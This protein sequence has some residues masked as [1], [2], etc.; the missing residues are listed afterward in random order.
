MNTM[1]DKEL[2]EIFGR[3]NPIDEDHKFTHRV[4]SSLPKK[5]RKSPSVLVWTFGI[6]G[7]MVAL[8]SGAIFRFLTYFLKFGIE[9][10]KAQTPD[11]SSIAIY[12]VVLVIVAVASFNMM[13]RRIS[14][15]F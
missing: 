12:L 3:S 1:S 2:K 10:T 7:L 15:S 5:E 14:L 13:K 9:L 11:V 6:A 4:M 8:F